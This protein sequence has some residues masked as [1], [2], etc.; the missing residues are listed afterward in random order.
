MEPE[1]EKKQKETDRDNEREEAARAEFRGDF[2][3]FQ[4]GSQVGRGIVAIRQREQS[5]DEEEQQ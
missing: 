5:S 4:T 2:Q 1:K 3:I